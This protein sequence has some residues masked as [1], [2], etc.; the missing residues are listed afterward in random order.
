MTLSD[1][2][3]IRSLAN[4]T[5]RLLTLVDEREI[6]E[7]ERYKKIQDT[8]IA[9]ISKVLVK[10][11]QLLQQVDPNKPL[12]FSKAHNK[13][14]DDFQEIGSLLVKRDGNNAIVAIPVTNGYLFTDVIANNSLRTEINERDFKGV[15]FELLPDVTE[16]TEKDL[17]FEIPRNVLWGTK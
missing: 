6:E 13:K 1:T 11:F 9:D 7:N 15:H 3:D 8:R 5:R 16:V 2:S 4:I 12:K 10:E 17:D 14:M